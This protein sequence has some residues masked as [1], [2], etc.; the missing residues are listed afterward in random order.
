MAAIRHQRV[1][2]Q[3]KKELADIIRT[4]IKDQRIG[5]TTVTRVEVSNDLQHAKVYVSVFGDPEQ[6]QVTL[7]VLQ[8]AA[9]FIRGEAS[10]RLRMRV[11]PEM[12]FVLDESGEYSAHIESVLKNIRGSSLHES[13]ETEE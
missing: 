8:K 4:D 12:V 10:R 2:E 7:S 5:F 3:M 9:G 11:T 13:R 1:A 6:K